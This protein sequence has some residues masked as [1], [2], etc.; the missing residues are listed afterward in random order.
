MDFQEMIDNHKA[1]GAGIT[2]ATIPV[3]A[4]DASDFGIMKKDEEG[5]ITSFTEKPKQDM[6]GDWVSDT[7]PEMQ[8]R[9]RCTG[10]NGYIYFQ[11]RPV[12][13]PAGNGEERR[14]D[15]G[16]EIIPQSIGKYKVVS[17]QY[18]GYWTD[19]GNIHSF[20]EA[21]L[22]L[23]AEILIS[24]CLTTASRFTPVPACCRRR[25]SAAPLWRKP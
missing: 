10:V 11:P 24:T 12:I 23:T 18:D 7:G 13:R 19:I 15:F 14:Y 2:V 6:L 1:L 17:Y 20:F 22:G 8:S 21:N 25:K 3:N 16:K 4:K 5:Y 9:E